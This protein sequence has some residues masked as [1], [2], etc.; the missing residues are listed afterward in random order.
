[1]LH[2]CIVYSVLLLMC[3]ASWVY[4]RLGLAADVVAS[5]VYCRLGLA[6]DVCCF[7]GVL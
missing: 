7:M 1:L 6:A 4:C 3:V 2:G 5:W